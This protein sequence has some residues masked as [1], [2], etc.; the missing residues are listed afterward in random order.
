MTEVNHQALGQVGGLE[1]G[2]S[3]LHAGQIVI[4]LFATTQN[5][6]A[7][8]VALGLHNGHLSIFMHR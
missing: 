4:G 8:G 7:V 3:G 1:V 2:A 5:H 6:M